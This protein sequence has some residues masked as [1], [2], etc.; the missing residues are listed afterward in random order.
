MTSMEKLKYEHPLVDRYASK[1]MSYIWSPSMKFSTWRKLWLS[2]AE[3][4]QQLGLDISNEQLN[5][6]RAHLTDIDFER[7]EKEEKDC[8][9]D[10]MAHVRTFGS[11]CP[12]AKPIIHLGA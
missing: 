4:E 3:G 8:R 5:E 2:L 7:A 1:Q 9:H 6:M 12:L 11:V 10:V